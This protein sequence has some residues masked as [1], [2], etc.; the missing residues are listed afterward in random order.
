[1]LKDGMLTGTIWHASHLLCRTLGLG[2]AK[3]AR[4]EP[5]RGIIN[6]ERVCQ[7]MCQ[8]APRTAHLGGLSERTKGRFSSSTQAMRGYCGR[9]GATMALRFPS[10]VSRVRIPSAAPFRGRMLAYAG[11]SP[12]PLALST[13]RRAGWPERAL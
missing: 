6:V 5:L 1:M 10:R 8:M 9:P 3:P 11:I 12:T 13:G 4:T 7:F 2:A